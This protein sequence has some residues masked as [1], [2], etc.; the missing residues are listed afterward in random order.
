VLF[1]AAGNVGGALYDTEDLEVHQMP[2]TQFDPAAFKVQQR[3]HWNATS[4]ASE[5]W[6][7]EWERGAA[8]VTARL[9]EL[10]GLRSGQRVLDAA[11]GHG[12]PALSAARVVGPSGRVV[13][14]DISP[15]ML[16]VARRRAKAKGLD[17]VEFVEA[18]LES[19]DLGLPTGSF[20]VVLSRFGLMLATDHVAAF[21][22]LARMLVAGGVLAAAVWG[23][24]DSHLMSR[25]AIALSQVLKLPE[26]A[27]GL[28]GPFSM[29]DP[30]QL[31][32]ELETAGFADVSV[33]EQVAPFRLDSVD[34]YVR[35][36]KEALPPQFLQ[37]VR[38]RFGS[39]DAPEAWDAVARA[40]EP[41][42]EQDGTLPLPSTAL[43]LRAVK[44]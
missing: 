39:P 9:L 26:P 36:N 20:D 18:D 17:H 42:A 27:P 40:V 24:Q 13:G 15:A 16:A 2:P 41:Y 12:E 7:E 1:G 35:F 43:C 4:A 23:P 37:A 22:A 19:V 5:I 44:P 21:R 11:T 8:P 28:P 25:G 10:G 6:W 31:A 14:V 38:E 32:S 34:D 30:R 3:A 29:S 33:T